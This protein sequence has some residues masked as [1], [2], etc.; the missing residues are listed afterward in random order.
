MLFTAST[1]IVLLGTAFLGSSFAKP[2][3]EEGRGPFG[4]HAWPKPAPQHGDLSHAQL[5]DSESLP[6][7]LLST[8]F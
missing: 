6:L 4:P 1:S 3:N 8:S 7:V 2:I 5:P